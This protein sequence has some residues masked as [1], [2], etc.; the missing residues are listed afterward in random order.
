MAYEV[1]F[2]SCNICYE[3]RVWDRGVKQVRRGFISNVKIEEYR[4]NNFTTW[5]NKIRMG[6]G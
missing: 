3:G 5:E 6:R 2:W 4:K 1:W